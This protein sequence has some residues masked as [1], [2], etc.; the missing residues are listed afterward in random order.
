MYNIVLVTGSRAEYGIMKKLISKLDIS[1]KVNLKI[2]ACAM[3]MEEKYGY[4]YKEIE[5]DGFDIDLKV[6]MELRDTS[7]KTILK[8][9]SILQNSLAD[10]FSNNKF[11]LV[12]ILGDRYEMLSVVNSA[13]LNKIPICHIHGGEKTLG[14]YDEFIRHSITKMSHLHLASTEEYKKRIIQ[15]GEEVLKV[16][17]I[18]SLGVENVL[19][20]KLLTRE[21]LFDRLSLEINQEY[22][23][24]LFHPV[25]LDGIESVI[26]QTQELICALEKHSDDYSFIFIGSN[27]DSGSDEITEIINT[28][29]N[30]NRN[31]YKFKSLS[32]IEYHSLIKSSKGLIGNSSSGIIE[33]PSL[34]V[35]TLNIG[36]RQEG[37]VRGNSVID[38]ETSCVSITKGIEELI[39]KNEKNEIII[40][41]YYKKEASE[42]AYNIILKA[43]EDEI[44]IKK[45]FNDINL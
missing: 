34:G 17:N 22:F 35:N 41:P 33:V 32:T 24:V 19:T 28:Y 38:V 43:L 14:N 15:L 30:N 10:Y 9:M 3:H 11:D 31:S 39:I 13:V 20:E 40:N 2:V 16:H 21:E 4:T 18:G 36:D 25:T 6:N 26:Y 1:D 37:R 5:K 12:I 8:S 27:S 23:V 42:N 44:S 7:D 29:I 45:I